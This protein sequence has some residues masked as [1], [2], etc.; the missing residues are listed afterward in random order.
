MKRQALRHLTEDLSFR[1]GEL[2]TEAGVL[3]IA[4]LAIEKLFSIP[5]LKLPPFMAEP[6]V[7][8]AKLGVPAPAGQHR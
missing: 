6:A 8:Q 3:G 7:G 5:R 2:N 1:F 4:L